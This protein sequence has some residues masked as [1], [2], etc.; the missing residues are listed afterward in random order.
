MVPMI[1]RT[2]VV[3]LCV[4]M[5]EIVREAGDRMPEHIREHIV[6]LRAELDKVPQDRDAVKRCLQL[7]KLVQA[8]VAVWEAEAK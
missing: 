4:A 3:A 2:I 7:T 8:E 5:E 6:E 1:G